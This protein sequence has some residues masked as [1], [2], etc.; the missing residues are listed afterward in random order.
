MKRDMELIRKIVLILD[1]DEVQ[2]AITGIKDVDPNVFGYHARLLIDAGLAEG[3]GYTTTT[4]KYTGQ[5]TRLTWEGHEYAE[6]MRD[7][8][9]WMKFRTGV[10]DTGKSFTLGLAKEYLTSL[11]REKLGLDLGR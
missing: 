5:L 8:S 4:F 3:G 11:A 2:T 6:L 10:L 7:D 1:S 9:V